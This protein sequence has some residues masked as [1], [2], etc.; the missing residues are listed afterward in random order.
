MGSTELMEPLMK[1]FRLS[2]AAFAIITVGAAFGQQSFYVSPKGLDNNPGTKSEPFKTFQKAKETV[3]IAIPS[4]KGDISV[5]FAGGTYPITKTVEFGPEDSPK[6][7]Y[8]VFYKAAKGEKPV[9]T[10]G[11]PLKGWTKHNDKLWKAPLKRDKKLRALY[12]NDQRAVMACSSRKIDAKG[13]WGHYDVKAGQA[14][15]AWKSGRTADGIKYG[16]ASLPEIKRNLFDVEI[17]NQ[18]TWNKNFIGVRDI[19]KEGGH[20]I[21]KLQQPYGAIAQQ[22]G[23]HA[24][25][26]LDGKHIIH[27]AFELL[28]TPGE[29]YF[30]RKEQTVY[31]YPHLTDDMTTAEVIVPVTE[32]LLRIEGEVPS[33]LIKNLVFD[34]LSFTHTDYNLVEI[35]GSYGKATI[36]TATV[37]TAFANPNWHYD[38]YRSYDVVP[39]AVIANGVENIEFIRNTITHT[40]CDGLVMSNGV[41]NVKIIGNTIRDAGGSTIT[42][43]HPQHVYENDTPDLKHSEGAGIDKEKYQNGSES[44]PRDILIANNFLPENAAL[45]NGH[46][47]ITAF[48]TNGLRIEHNFIPNAP[49][50]GIS[51][52][53]GWCDFDGSAVAKHPKWGR[54]NR[55]AVFPGKPTTIAKNNSIRYNRIEDVMTILHDGGSI[56]TLGTMPN[57][58]IE[59]NYCRNMGRDRA[60]YLDEGSSFITCRKNVVQGPYQWAHYTQHFGRLRDLVVENYFVTKWDQNSTF[61][62]CDPNNWPE[63][64]Q[65]IINKSGL[66]PEW[67]YLA[68]DWLEAH[69][70]KMEA[71]RIAQIE[72]AEQGGVYEAEYAKL[73]GCSTAN[74]HVDYSGT[75]FV[76]GF[77]NTTQGSMT[78]SVKASKAGSH[79]MNLRYAAGNGDC[80]S[81]AL[82]INGEKIKTLHCKRTGAWAKWGDHSEL[83]TL[84][85]GLNKIEL[86]A[87]SASKDCMNIDYIK[88]S[89]A[90]KIK[91]SHDK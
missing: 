11:V 9:F 75:G 87:E 59:E 36:Q 89:N 88:I 12:V 52:G 66:E 56:Y 5:I 38:V 4:M 63:G 86:K 28:D 31:Y 77:Y 26:T 44:M 80:K 53:W 20:Y 16:I 73:D 55:P 61:I 90:T 79:T 2:I 71:A 76:A 68:D 33:G 14:D 74:D 21:F 51:A 43:G 40:G 32:T 69:A 72:R 10:G 27:N 45:F 39:G 18:T 37:L 50:S 23:W 78:F 60:I 47:I 57:S 84:N 48:F 41:K 82:H 49:Y 29:F 42:I 22:A 15:W 1:K 8:K 19:V 85:A 65:T 3:R 81:V 25:L 34:G 24:G 91:G 70:K 35:D 46:T 64:A 17:E 62:T 58:F 13:G 67:K 83:V 30:D 6:D 54:G 7:T